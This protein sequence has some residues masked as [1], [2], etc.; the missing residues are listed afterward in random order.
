MTGVFGEEDRYG[1]DLDK[2]SDSDAS[3]DNNDQQIEE[4]DGGSSDS[5]PSF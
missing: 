1:A 4:S 2:E 3:D 5:E